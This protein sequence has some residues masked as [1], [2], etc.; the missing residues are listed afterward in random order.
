[1]NSYSQIEVV[2]D[3]IV[4]SGAKWEKHCHY[5]CGNYTAIIYMMMALHYSELH[6]PRKCTIIT[7]TLVG[8]ILTVF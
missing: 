4:M 6:L 7:W 5:Y 2:K 3:G 1:M 8:T